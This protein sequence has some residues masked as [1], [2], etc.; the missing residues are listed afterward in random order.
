MSLVYF[1]KEVLNK[2][3]SEPDK[4]S[5]G[6]GYVRMDGIWSLQIDNDRRDDIV[7]ML[8]DLNILNKKEQLHWRSNNI[9]PPHEGAGLSE[10]TFGRWFLGKWCGPSVAGDLVL[11]S[12]YTLFNQAWRERYKWDLFLPLK[13]GDEVRLQTLHLITTND[14]EL[15]FENQILA[16]SKI[17]IDSLNQKALDNNIDYSMQ[18][19]ADYK[20]GIGNRS[21]GG[22]D[23]FV[24]FNLTNGHDIK[25]MFDF[26]KMLQ[27][28]RST[29]VAHRKSSNIKDL[30]QVRSYFGMDELHLKDV[31]EEIFTNT[32]KTLNTLSEVYLS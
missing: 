16:L 23:K 30:Q 32:I 29:E 19:V 6:D 14:N 5:V 2:Y 11:V 31:L 20:S 7:I 10:C 13:N 25:P 28:L 22:I 15:D 18:D 1:N 27:R 17:F 21:I 8:G 24:M 12:K 9:I 3:Y 4:Y 26:F